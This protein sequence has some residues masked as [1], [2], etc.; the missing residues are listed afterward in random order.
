[1]DYALFA[2]MSFIRAFWRGIGMSAGTLRYVA[3]AIRG[4]ERAGADDSKARS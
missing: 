4:G 1:M 3:A 2:P